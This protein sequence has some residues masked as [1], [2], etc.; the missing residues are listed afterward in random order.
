MLPLTRILVVTHVVCR[1][2]LISL[3]P[4]HPARGLLLILQFLVPSS[5]PGTGKLSEGERLQ[6]AL[7]RL[8]PIFIKFGQLLATRQDMLPPEWTAALARL[9]DQVA[10]FDGEQARAIVESEL[11]EPFDQVFSHFDNVPLASASVAQVHAATLHNGQEVVAKVL[12]PDIR[13]TVERDLKVMAFGARWLERLWADARYFRPAQVVRDYQDIIL[14]ELDLAA[15]A[16]NSEAMRRHFLFSPLLYIPAIHTSLSTSRLIIMDRIYGIPVNDIERIRAAG[17]D[18]KVLAERG[19]EIFFSQVFR[20]NLFHADMHPGNIF[21]NPEHPE[22]PQYMAVDAAIA[23][24]LSKDDLNVLGRMV[25]AVMRE[26][27][28]ALVDAVIRAGWNTSPIDRPRFERAV[29]D[30]VEPVRSAQLDQ[31]EFAPLVM[32]LFDLARTHHI[33]MPVQ[34]ILL[35]KT[36][37]HIEGLG[38]SIY[39]QLDIWN[40]GRPLLEAWMLAEYGPSATLKKLQNRLPE[41]TAQLPDMPDLLRDGLESLRDLP[42]QQDRLEAR[43]EQTLIRHRHKLLAGLAGLA[44]AGAALWLASPASWP[45][46]GAAVLLVGW[47]W[48][49]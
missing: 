8:G 28:S 3:L 49:R 22:S 19:V 36:L 23:G 16:R 25:L 45:L 27:Y 37:V 13:P 30:L 17:I 48:R 14:G 32:K 4:P 15:E 43:L 41:W 24:R 31:L 44:T 6:L 47:S 5:W 40:T 1:Y 29:V 35:M 9:Q 11:P 21:V 38:R 34:Y 18:P 46:A 39:P 7:E 2:R 26:D 12:R 33:E 42:Y 20:F 10:P